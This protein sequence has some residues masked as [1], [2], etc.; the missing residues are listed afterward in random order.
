MEVVKRSKYNSSKNPIN[1]VLQNRGVPQDK[2]S[3]YIFPSDKMEPDWK[4]LDNIEEGL[5]LLKKHID[6]ESDILV[7]VDMDMDGFS[8][9]AIITQFIKKQLKH[10]NIRYYTPPTKAHGINIEALE[11]VGLPDLLI[12]PDAGSS[13]F[14]EHEYLNKKGVEVLVIDHHVVDENKYSEDALVINNQLSEDFEWKALTGSAMTYLFV[15]AFTQNYGKEYSLPKK[16]YEY[17]LDL[18]AVGLVADRASFLDSGSFYYVQQGLSNV[19]NELFKFIMEDDSNL[20]VDGELTPKN[21]GFN[22]APYFNAMTREGKPEETKYVTD[23]LIGE[24]YEVYNK[25][26]KKECT[27]QEEALRKMKSTRSRQSKKVKTAMET[28]LERIEE[29]G[30]DENKIVLVNATGIIEDASYNGLVAT[31]IAKEYRKPVLVMSVFKE[32]GVLRGSGRNINDSP[33]EDLRKLLEDT[34]MFNYV[35]GHA[36]AFGFEMPLENAH[37]IIEVIN[38]AL[39]DVEYENK[40]HVVDFS[41][42]SKPDADDIIE[43]ANH[44]HIWGNDLEAPLIHVHSIYMDKDDIEFIGKK[45]NTWKMSFNAA[46][47]IMFNLSEEQKMRLVGHETDMIELEIVGQCDLNTFK[48]QEYPQV[49]IKDFSAKPL[50]GEDGN[51]WSAIEVDALPF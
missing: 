26:L 9:F 3:Q 25:R 18:C 24:E 6:D 8:S 49:I 38:S 46:S 37:S 4:K 42:T 32:E 48:G 47:G 40:R 27:V 23:A 7:T 2:V 12:V 43:I 15:K 13:D 36:G 17:Y 45:G 35:S 29:K 41:Y 22:L 39:Y 51:P 20:S 28:L 1:F 10:D 44:Q 5:E 31:E 16:I 21:V 14:E 33:I 34:E 50:E 30:S 19:K 11:E